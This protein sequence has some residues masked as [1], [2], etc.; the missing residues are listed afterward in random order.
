M[1]MLN[2]KMLYIYTAIYVHFRQKYSYYLLIL[3]LFLYYFYIGNKLF[4]R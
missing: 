1:K 2:L 3:R 4:Q